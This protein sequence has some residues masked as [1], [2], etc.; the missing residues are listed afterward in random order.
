MVK[1]AGWKQSKKVGWGDLHRGQVVTYQTNESRE[2]SIA[3]V[4][5]NIKDELKVECHACRSVW[6]GTGIHH[7]KEYHAVD[8][9]GAEIVLTPTES[10]VKII[11]PYANLVRVVEL[12]VEGRM[13]QGDASALSKGGW[14]FKV[15]SQ[16]KVR[17]ISEAMVLSRIEDEKPLEF[18]ERE[19]IMWLADHLVKDQENYQVV[20]PDVL[21]EIVAVPMKERRRLLLKDES[22]KGASSLKVPVAD[23]R[24]GSGSSPSAPVSHPSDGPS[25]VVSA[26]NSL[27][28]VQRKKM[29]SMEKSESQGPSLKSD[30]LDLSLI[31]I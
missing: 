1:A 12:Y 8:E 25:G 17:A 21:N 19:K 9:E 10:A 26:S 2:L 24:K 11:V 5:R 15:D 20:T 23:L 4:L 27:T 16:E 29:K 3:Y 13:M 18:S 28:S 22:K 14:T 6:K 31:H 30:V 7:L